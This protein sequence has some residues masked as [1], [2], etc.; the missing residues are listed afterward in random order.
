M[1]RMCQTDKFSLILICIN[2]NG[3]NYTYDKRIGYERKHTAY[4]V[5]FLIIYRVTPLLYVLDIP[6]Q[7]NRKLQNNTF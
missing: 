4:K 1:V 2:S 6:L 7:V 3:I 5:H